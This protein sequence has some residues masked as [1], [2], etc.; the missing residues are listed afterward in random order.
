MQANMRH[1]VWEKRKG[2]TRKLKGKFALNPKWVSKIM[3]KDKD[4][5]DK[6]AR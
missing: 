2:K 3:E 5:D 1:Q 6:P 4:E